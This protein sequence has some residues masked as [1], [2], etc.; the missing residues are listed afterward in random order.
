MIN[1]D[2]QEAEFSAW[3]LE[4][5]LCMNPSSVPY[6]LHVLELLNF[7]ISVSSFVK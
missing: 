6:S 7:F 5:D 1:T 3:A 4:Q 2:N